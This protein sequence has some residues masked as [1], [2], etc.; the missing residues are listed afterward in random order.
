MWTI[1]MMVYVARKIY[2]IFTHHSILWWGSLHVIL[3]ELFELYHVNI[4]FH[5]N[6]S[7][8]M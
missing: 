3:F 8:D 1:D 7:M 4:T 6:I 2:L 5:R